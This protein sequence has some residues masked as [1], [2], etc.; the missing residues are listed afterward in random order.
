ME[1]LRHRDWCRCSKV[2]FCVG[3]RICFVGYVR[4]ASLNTGLGLRL[5][6]SYREMF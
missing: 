2:E 5:D 1:L 3:G 4:N 6:D